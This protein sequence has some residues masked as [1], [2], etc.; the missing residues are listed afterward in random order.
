MA[1][2]ST[3]RRVFGALLVL[4]TVAVVPMDTPRA[5]ALSSVPAYWGRATTGAFHHS[6]PTMADVN[7][8]G[9]PDI[10]VGD[11]SGQVHVYKRDG[12]RMPG[13]PRLAVLPGA[14][15]AS[16]IESTPAVADLDGDGRK[17]IIVGVGSLVR[18]NQQGGLLIFN[19]DGS[20]RCGYRTRDVFNQWTGGGPDGYSEAVFS[21]PAVGD[22][23]GDGK[24]DIVFA[25]FDHRI[26]AIGKNCGIVH[27][28]PFDNKDTVWSSPALTNADQDA[29]KEIFIGGDSSVPR[30]GIL[31]RFD[32]RA[33]NLREVWERRTDEIVQSSPA[34]GDI[35]G[36]G[37]RELV[38][39]SGLFYRN[40][41]SN[42]VWARRLSDGTI[43]PGWP[44]T[45]GGQ[46]FSSP[47]LGDIT[48]DGVSDVVIGARDTKV[49]AFRGTGKLIWTRKIGGG[50]LL[51]SPV[52][53]DL[54]GKGNRDVAMVTSGS[55]WLINGGSG[56]LLYNPIASTYAFQNAAAVFNFRDRS[57]RL[58][59]AGFKPDFTGGFVGSYRLPYASRTE[60]WPMFRRNRYHWGGPLT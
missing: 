31:R 1:G 50:D 23:T 3:L 18:P 35:T 15:H 6:A 32:W 49:Y 39:G 57:T 59:I 54:N 43:L 25:G 14:S 21:S 45:L 17:E 19:R 30:G 24:R 22:I 46:V 2:S 7:N 16:A 28:F 42:R 60:A 26:Y 29:R 51:S 5:G 55:V 27:G 47:A 12:S 20:R 37:K 38:V 44:R 8:D 4:L 9:S 56:T 36:D 52:I 58:F 41:D 33:G 13:W 48:G 53:A 10:V 40:T 34:I 11:L